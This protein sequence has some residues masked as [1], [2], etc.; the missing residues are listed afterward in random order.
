MYIYAKT[1]KYA[2]TKCGSGREIRYLLKII[3]TIESEMKDNLFEKV[4]P[5][6]KKLHFRW[7]TILVCLRFDSNLLWLCNFF[8]L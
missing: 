1:D 2:G 5:K 6:C 4:T 3:A 8:L 7:N